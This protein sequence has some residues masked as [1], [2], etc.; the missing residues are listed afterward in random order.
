MK[1]LKAIRN[2]A[3]HILNRAVEHPAFDEEL[4]KKQDYQALADVGGDIFDWTVTAIEAAAAL[5][6]LKQLVRSKT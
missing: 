2:Y 1:E 5:R 3:E 4:F 6:L